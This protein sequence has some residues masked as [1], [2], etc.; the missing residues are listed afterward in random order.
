MA[1]EK[2]Q[3]IN[4]K[5]YTKVGILATAVVAVALLG[6][7]AISSMTKN[8]DTTSAVETV[9]TEDTK[10]EAK[11]T[12]TSGLHIGVVSMEK[13][14]TEGKVLKDLQK[15]RTNYETKLKK[16]LEK[17]QKDLEKEK[18]EIEKSQD[19]LSPDALQRRVVD[20][21][22]RA[23]NAQRDLAEKA[24]AIEVSY[25][26]ALNKV[27]KEYLDPVIDNIIKKQQLSFV[28]D[29][30]VTHMG[31]GTGVSDITKDVIKSLDKKV[32]SIKME[33]PKGF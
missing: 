4:V 18:N 28:I 14:I 9:V 30:R 20:L 22:R 13:I 16:E 1:K 10:T 31:T 2:Q 32:S 25:Q 17:V 6:A 33:K 5:K 15:Q 27:E 3:N 24:Q 19:V 8:S 29:A 7:W 12:T 21:Q 11:T 23:N 26:E